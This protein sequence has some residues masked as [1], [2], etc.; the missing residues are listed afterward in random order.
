M[1]QHILQEDFL[2]DRRTMRRLATV[3]ATFIAFTAALAV[4]IGVVLG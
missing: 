4:G 3:V 1:T 2:E